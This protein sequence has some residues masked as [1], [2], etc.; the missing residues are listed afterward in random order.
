VA[1]ADAAVHDYTGLHCGAVVLN[2]Q[3]VAQ[4]HLMSQADY[5]S[6]PNGTSKG[7]CL[8]AQQANSSVVVLLGVA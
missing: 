1:C 6:V 7:L 2:H 5:Q 3:V 4:Q 8:V